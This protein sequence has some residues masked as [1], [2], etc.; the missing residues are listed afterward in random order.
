MLQLSKT[1]IV[2]V[3][4]VACVWLWTTHSPFRM[5][6]NDCAKN[7]VYSKEYCIWMY[8]EMRK[9]ESWLRK[10]LLELGY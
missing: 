4:I 3:T 7:R 10:I 6:V 8:M 5:Y 1:I 9:E 2:C